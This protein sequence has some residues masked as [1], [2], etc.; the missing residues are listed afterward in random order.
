M[1][2][3]EH[4]SFSLAHLIRE[5]VQTYQKRAL[6]AG[7]EIRMVNDFV[8][9]IQLLADLHKLKTLFGFAIRNAIDHSGATVITLSSRQLLYFENHVLV[10]FCITD[11]GQSGKR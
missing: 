1:N 5:S 9:D 7:I 10:E 2:S 6:A 4:Q 11:N 3:E 8:F